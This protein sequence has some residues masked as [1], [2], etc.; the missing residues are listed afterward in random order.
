MTAIALIFAIDSSLTNIS[1]THPKAGARSIADR[2]GKFSTKPP[3]DRLKTTDFRLK[4]KGLRLAPWVLG[5]ESKVSSLQYPE[6]QNKRYYS[7]N[8]HQGIVLQFAGC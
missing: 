6:Y 1:A 7:G 8:H 3:K 5:L 2:T 4:S